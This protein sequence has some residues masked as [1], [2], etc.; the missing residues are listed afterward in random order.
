MTR[1]EHAPAVGADMRIAQVPASS[2]RYQSTARP[3]LTQLSCQRFQIFR[4][5]NPSSDAIVSCG[6][7]RAGFQV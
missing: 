2:R 7:G 4:I 5:S 3:Q 6:D 1:T